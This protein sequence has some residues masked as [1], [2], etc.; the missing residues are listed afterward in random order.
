[1]FRL[2]VLSCVLAV[3]LAK[4]GLRYRDPEEGFFTVAEE[5]QATP[6]AKKLLDQIAAGARA[7]M[8]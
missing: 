6:S 1:M 8:E 7:R 5:R 2:A 3:S 4:P